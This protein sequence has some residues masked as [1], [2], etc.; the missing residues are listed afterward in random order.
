M[1]KLITITV[2]MAIAAHAF[3]YDFSAMCESGQTLYYNILSD[4]EVEITYPSS[5]SGGSWLGYIHP[6][7]FL[8]IPATVEHEGISYVVVS[9]GNRAFYQCSDLTGVEIPNT[10]MSLQE[11]AFTGA[12]LTSLEI[13]NSVT[14]IGGWA[15]YHCDELLSL[16]IGS[17][18]SSIGTGAF[19]N[20]QHLE[21]IHCITPAPPSYVFFYDFMYHFNSRIFQGVHN[22]IPVYVNC[23]SLNQFQSDPQWKQFTNLIG[24]FVGVPELNVSCNVPG[25]GTTEIVSL[26]EDCDHNTA[27][28]R[29]IPNPGH[30]FCYWKN[31]ME[32]VSTSPEYTFMLDQNTSLIACFDCLPIVYDSIAYPDHVVGRIFDSTGQIAYEH[33]SDFIYDIYG[34]LIKYDFPGL[35]VSDYVFADNPILPSG[36]HN[37]RYYYPD[38]EVNEWFYYTFDNNTIKYSEKYDEMGKLNA[39]YYSYDEN[40]RI[41]QIKINN[42]QGIPMKLNLF[43]YADNYRTKIDSY[44]DLY[45]TQTLLTQTTSHYNERQQVLSIQVDTYDDT[46]EITSKKLNTYSY[47]SNNKT[48]NIITQ[49]FTNEEWVNTNIAYFVYD[50]KNRVVEYKTGIWSPENQDWNITRKTVYDFNDEEQ[51][52]I[53]SFFQK[54]GDEWVWHRYTGSQPILYKPELKTYE[55]AIYGYHGFGINQFEIDLHY[56]RKEKEEMFPSQSE[57]YYEIQNDNGNITYQHLEY[58]ADTTIGNERPKIIIRSNTQ[59]DRDTITEVTHEYILEANNKVYWWNKDLEEFTTL[60]DYTA[61]ADDEWEIKVGTESIMVHV[62]SVGLFE[63]QGDTRKVLHISDAGDLFNGDI[64]VGYGHMTSFFPEKLMNRGKGF[65]VDGLR[66]YW[67]GDALLYHNGEEDCDAI[68]SELQGLD[69]P[70]DDTAFAVY[71]NP[72]NNILFVETQCIASQPTTTYRITNLMGQTVLSGNITAENQQI[73]ISSLPAGMYF[74][75]VSEQTRKFVK[76]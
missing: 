72:A 20:C 38:I 11:Q 41:L 52:L 73:D 69:E 57:W 64:V 29:A 1:K 51:K 62:D 8:I 5:L 10:V 59:Y 43:E 14:S 42:S 36:I 27:T 6:T 53:I 34:Q 3:A 2:L 49:T 63:Y 37:T 30:E 22:D 40:W 50:D 25:L 26:P 19:Q 32:A 66:C 46:R 68:H 58:T 17:S 7:G 75:S 76:Q 61:E 15:F 24:T 28:V 33:S 23:L 4:H 67:V 71:P 65:R 13:P 21:S 60:Y 54:N 44:Y 35:I 12:G 18:V 9:V 39:T 74:I 70:M 31:G 56:V 16:T 48:D 47:T 55:E 45:P